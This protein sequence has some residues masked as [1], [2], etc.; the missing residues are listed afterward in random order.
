[1]T[2]NM[3]I[4]ANPPHERL[5]PKAP[6]LFTVSPKVV[7]VARCMISS[8]SRSYAMADLCNASSLEP[9]M[10]GKTCVV[11]K[12][13]GSMNPYRASDSPNFLA[14]GKMLRYA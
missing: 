8:Q 3:T 9:P 13:A 10:V 14:R 7:E 2:M 6:P 11:P 1:M 5:L 12:A 4:L